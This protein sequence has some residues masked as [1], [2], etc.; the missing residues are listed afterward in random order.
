M[1]MTI[2]KTSL[3]FLFLTSTLALM[4]SCDKEDTNEEFA[5]IQF[6]K[7]KVDICHNGKI[8]N[9]SVNAVPAHQNHGDAVDMDGD[10]YFD[11]A[12]ECG[13]GEADCNDND[14]AVNPGAEEVADGIDNN[15]DGNI[16]EGVCSVGYEVSDFNGVPYLLVGDFEPGVYTWQ[17][18]IDQCAAKAAAEGCGWYLP[19]ND[20]ANNICDQYGNQGNQVWNSDDFGDPLIGRTSD[21]D[22]DKKPLPKT[23]ETPCRCVR[24][25]D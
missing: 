10:G 2:F 7:N 20:D 6:K 5:E 16:D 9:V 1:K 19:N 18:A 3:I 22:C 21:S 24:P 13:T 25:L 4:V 11:K 15:C 12:S 17:G 23:F 8:I 14:P